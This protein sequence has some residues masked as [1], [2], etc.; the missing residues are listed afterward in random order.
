MRFVYLPVCVNQLSKE[1][2]M[3][4]MEALSP[5]IVAGYREKRLGTGLSSSS[6]RLELRCNVRRAI[7]FAN[8]L[9]FLAS[10]CA[11]IGTYRV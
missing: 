6:V 2:G 8:R 3:Y 5:D 1:L 4:S 11:K 10:N 7:W 9:I